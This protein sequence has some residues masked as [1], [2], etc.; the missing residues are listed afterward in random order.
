MQKILAKI[1]ELF[2][3]YFGLEKTKMIP[4]VLEEKRGRF[5]VLNTESFKRHAYKIPVDKM[6]IKIVDNINKEK[7]GI[8]IGKMIANNLVVS[9]DDIIIKREKTHAG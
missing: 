8:A 9:F 2:R 7:L 6:N 3:I 4:Q 5:M 1:D